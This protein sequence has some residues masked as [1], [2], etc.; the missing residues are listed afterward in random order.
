MVY[1]PLKHWVEMG[2]SVPDYALKAPGWLDTST[3]DLDAKLPDQFVPKAPSQTVDQKNLAEMQKAM[4]D[5][6]KA[7]AEMM[8]NLLIERFGL[9]WHEETQTVSGYELVTDKK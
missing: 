9:K 4:A 6:Q 1:A 3:F 2:L 7:M 5:K 8:R